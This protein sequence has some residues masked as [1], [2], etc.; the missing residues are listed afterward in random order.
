VIFGTNGGV[1]YEIND[2]TLEVVGRLNVP[3][4]VVNKVVI[5]S[6]G[7][8]AF[9][10]TYMNELYAYAPARCLAFRGRSNVRNEKR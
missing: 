4:A 8:R 6:G 10:P 1:V 3:D 5:A 2:Q 9:V 7:M